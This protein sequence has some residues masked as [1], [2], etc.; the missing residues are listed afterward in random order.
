SQGNAHPQVVQLQANINEL[1]AR[2]DAEIT[3]VTSSVSI[4]NT[5]NLSREAQVR[6]ALEAQRE[7]I[8]HL[9]AQR[10]EASVLVSDVANAQR[11]Y[12]ALQARYAQ[13]SLESQSNQTDVSILKY[14]SPPAD[15][16]FPKMILNTAISIVLGCMLSV[17]LAVLRETRDRRIRLEDDILTFTKSAFLGTMPVALEAKKGALLPVKSPPRLAKRA[18]PELTAPKKA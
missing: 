15:A 2:I 11:A 16:S 8:L 9:K 13:T 3:R 14:A 7:K 6:A 10:D 12:D 17:G 18:L 1:R 4:N 5:V